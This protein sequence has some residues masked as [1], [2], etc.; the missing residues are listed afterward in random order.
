MEKPKTFV[1]RTQKTPQQMS[2]EELAVYINQLREAGRLGM[3]VFEQYVYGTFPKFTM[4]NIAATNPE[5]MWDTLGTK[6]MRCM[7]YSLIPPSYTNCIVEPYET[8]PNTPHTPILLMDLSKEQPFKPP[9]I[10]VSK[11]NLNSS[12]HTKH[13]NIHLARTWQES[14]NLK[15][16]YNNLASEKKL[17]EALKN[18][19]DIVYSLIDALIKDYTDSTITLH[20]HNEIVGPVSIPNIL[21]VGMPMMFNKSLPWHEPVN[22]LHG[23]L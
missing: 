3:M 20:K 16:A 8:L 22:M 10:R 12:H 23:S 15:K 9:I 19:P 21:C 18:N 6:N 13:K 14:E 2:G 11:A 1:E 5:I 17:F 4:E 7:S